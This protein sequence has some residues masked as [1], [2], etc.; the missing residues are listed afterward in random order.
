VPRCLFRRD[1]YASGL[2]F[3]VSSLENQAITI[4]FE[5]TGT[6]PLTGSARATLRVD[7]RLKL[8]VTKSCVMCGWVMRLAGAIY[9]C[10]N[11]ACERE[12][13]A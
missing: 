5:D 10:S 4:K 12:E 7:R 1:A 11:R 3:D 8:P 9:E 2:R 13:A 6:G